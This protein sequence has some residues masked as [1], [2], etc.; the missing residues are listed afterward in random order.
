MFPGTQTDGGCSREDR[1]AGVSSYR[2]E[3]MQTSIAP[4]VEEYESQ[5]GG[6]PAVRGEMSWT[7]L[8]LQ[9]AAY[10][11]GEGSFQPH[12][13]DMPDIPYAYDDFGDTPH[14]NVGISLR[15]QTYDP[16]QSTITISNGA[17]REPL[18]RDRHDATQEHAL[19]RRIHLVSHIYADPDT[20]CQD[21]DE[22]VGYAAHEDSLDYRFHAADVVSQE[23]E[24]HFTARS[25][26]REMMLQAEARLKRSSGSVLG[27]SSYGNY[28]V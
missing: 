21:Y 13:V 20:G 7:T 12:G 26:R 3:M 25:D 8:D 27:R 18:R 2:Y 5:H 14:T 10:A 28:G 19:N 17:A 23:I 22:A 9:P 11:P 24:P 6:M 16:F 15:D 1:A 4:T